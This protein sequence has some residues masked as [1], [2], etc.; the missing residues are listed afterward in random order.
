MGG[1]NAFEGLVSDINEIIEIATQA[2]RASEAAL[3]AAQLA[4]SFA[5]L[6]QDAPESPSG[7]TDLSPDIEQLTAALQTAQQSYDQAASKCQSALRACRELVRK[8]AQA[9]EHARAVAKHAGR[10]GRPPGGAAK[11]PQRGGRGGRGRRARSPSSGDAEAFIRP[12]DQ[13]P[14]QVPLVT[15]DIAHERLPAVITADESYHLAPGHAP[16]SGSLVRSPK[17]SRRRSSYG[18]SLPPCVTGDGADMSDSPEHS[19]GA[20]AGRASGRASGGGRKRG[21]KPQVVKQEEEDDAMR[22]LVSRDGRLRYG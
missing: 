6:M 8:H 20:G 12:R 18:P 5:G 2:Q 11:Q 19:G 10:R 17:G 15:P 9:A 4:E 7:V 14:W 1:F 22:G 3:G 16:R 21:R 13:E